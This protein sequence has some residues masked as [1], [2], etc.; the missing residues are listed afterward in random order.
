M[1]QVA[2]KAT[3]GNG[4]EFTGNGTAEK[5]TQC[6]EQQD[7]AHFDNVPHIAHVNAVI[8]EVRHQKRDDDLED[9]LTAD[10]DHGQYGI[11]FLFADA[12]HQF[13][14]HLHRSFLSFAAFR[15]RQHLHLFLRAVNK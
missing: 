14:N 7:N 6:G 11:L 2:G 13:F 12:F 5:L 8:D 10:G 15:Q 4:C 9:D 3:G 1:A